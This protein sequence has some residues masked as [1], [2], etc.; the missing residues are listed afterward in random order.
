MSDLPPPTRLV[1]VREQTLVRS[2]EHI[3]P[4]VARD[5]AK[6]FP[7]FVSKHGLLS[8]T[9]LVSIGQEA[10]YSAAHS[11]RD[12]FSHDFADF[13]RRRVRGAMLDAL[14]DLRYEQRIG[15]AALIASDNYCA[16]HR[17]NTYNVLEHG[18]PEEAT[19][20]L[21]IFANGLL[22]ATFAAAV[23]EA[24]RSG[25][26]AEFAERQEYEVALRALKSALGRLAEPDHKLL[27]LVYCDLHDLKT[28]SLKLGLPYIRVRRRHDAALS[29]LKAHLVA[30]GVA[31][32]PPTVGSVDLGD[33]TGFTRPVPENDQQ[34][35]PRH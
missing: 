30:Q 1:P 33:V 32:A 12:E 9:D 34:P 20:R 13:A 14:D 17:D 35:K 10:L 31:R 29:Q 24:A 15:R 4:G 11:F 3:L 19:R 22:A 7:R 27:V 16:Y 2:A 18:Y 8:A 28:A 23:E 25:G 5:V 6:K 26:E 21:R